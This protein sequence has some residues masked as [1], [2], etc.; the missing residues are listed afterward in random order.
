[1]A[2]K[3]YFE[4]KDYDVTITINLHTRIGFAPMY[5]K[6]R[7]TEVD[8]IAN[9]IG[10]MPAEAWQEITDGFANE[11]AVDTAFTVKELT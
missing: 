2:K 8:A 9:A 10:H 3:S 1:M 11:F 7:I 4:E 5:R 6:G